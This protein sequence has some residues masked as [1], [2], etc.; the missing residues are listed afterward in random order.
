MRT[1]PPSEAS[2][3]ANLLLFQSHPLMMPALHHPEQGG[4]ISACPEGQTWPLSSPD[5]PSPEG[6]LS[7]KAG[8]PGLVR[9]QDSPLA[10]G[11]LVHLSTFFS[12]LEPMKLGGHSQA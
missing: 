7:P 12:Q 3:P 5:S 8:P 1:T 6:S 2:T 4:T 11:L 10:H 9:Q